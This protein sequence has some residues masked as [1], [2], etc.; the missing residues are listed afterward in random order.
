MTKKI[1][2]PP[3]A[4]DEEVRAIL[5]RYDCQVPFHE[6][7]TRFLGNIA[8]PAMEATPMKIVESLWG[9]KLPPFE[10]IDALNEL[11][12]ALVMG[13]WNRLSKHQDRTLPFR[14]TRIDTGPTRNGL[15]ALS[16][17]RRQELDG[18]IDG[19]FGPHAELDFPERARR[20][21]DALEEMRALFGAVVEAAGDAAVPGTQKD[22]EKTLRLLGEITK[23]AE[24][25]IHAIVRSCARARQQ[26]L[27]TMPALKPTLH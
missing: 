19:L 11:I 24:M 7:R 12:G 21:L 14:L 6:V 17:T 13:L 27:T 4:T 25:E 22:M 26:F 1:P 18:F 5:K 3:T 2:L 23:N 10:T 16:L 15:A 9:G 8:T 20:G